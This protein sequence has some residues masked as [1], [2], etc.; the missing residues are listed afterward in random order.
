MAAGAKLSLCGTFLGYAGVP[1][2][3][4]AALWVHEPEATGGPGILEE[5]RE[6]GD[7]LEMQRPVL[8]KADLKPRI[9]QLVHLLFNWEY[10][11]HSGEGNSYPLHYS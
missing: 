9:L 11:L 6:G 10:G 7:G 2:G 5:H 8:Q 4:K 1:G 3:K